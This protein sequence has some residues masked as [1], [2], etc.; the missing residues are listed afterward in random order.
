MKQTSPNEGDIVGD[1]TMHGVTRPL[2]LHVKLMTPAT[3]ADAATSARTRWLVSTDPIRRKDFRL[4]FGS[5]AET[6]SG[7]GQEVVPKIE[8]EAVR[9]AK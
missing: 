4:M 3:A 8:I 7:I 1:L 9:V 6:V 5:T 2:T